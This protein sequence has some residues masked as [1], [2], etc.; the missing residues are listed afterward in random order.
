MLPGVAGK[1]GFPGVP[2]VNGLPGKPGQPGKSVVS[3]KQMTDL[4]NKISKVKLKKG[5]KP[6]W[7][8][9]C[10]STERTWNWNRIIKINFWLLDPT[11]TS[12]SSLETR[13]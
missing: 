4:R 9:A 3:R 2:G 7:I 13:L 5:T 12:C 6:N 1:A 11:K 8:L 10:S